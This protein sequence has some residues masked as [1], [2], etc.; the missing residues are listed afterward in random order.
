[1]LASTL[2]HYGINLNEAV[3]GNVTTTPAVPGLKP[4]AA[5]TEPTTVAPS[6]K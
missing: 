4:A 6:E 3:T 2:T 5:G 1:V